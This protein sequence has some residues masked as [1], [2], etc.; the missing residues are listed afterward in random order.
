[1]SRQ[2]GQFRGADRPALKQ[3]LRDVALDRRELLVA[4]VFRA[5][6]SARQRIEGG[7]QPER[8]ERGL[9]AQML[10]G[11]DE[12]LLWELVLPLP[13]LGEVG[14]EVD[15]AAAVLTRCPVDVLSAGQRLPERRQDEIVVRV[16]NGEPDAVDPRRRAADRGDLPTRRR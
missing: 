4:E 9:A 6:G 1:V 5:A 8:N 13:D 2:V 10:P 16:E 14:R 12:P 7:Q 15:E 3:S 11:T